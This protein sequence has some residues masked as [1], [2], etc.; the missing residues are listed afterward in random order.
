MGESKGRGRGR[1]DKTPVSLCVCVWGELLIDD[2]STCASL[3]AHHA[4]YRRDHSPSSSDSRPLPQRA[5][6]PSAIGWSCDAV[7]LFSI[8]SMCPSF[9]AF[10]FSSRFPVPSPNSFCLIFTAKRLTNSTIL[11]GRWRMTNTE[12]ENKI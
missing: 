7:A 12:E 1:E 9:G 3:P 10:S 2:K 11:R 6:F 4:S 5:V 8:D